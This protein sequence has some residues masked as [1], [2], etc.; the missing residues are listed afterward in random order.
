MVIGG[1][2]EG[3]GCDLIV[4]IIPVFALRDWEKNTKKLSQYRRSLGRNLIA[5]PTEYEGVLTT[6]P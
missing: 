5:G 3:S 2:V 1:D 6:R 4:D